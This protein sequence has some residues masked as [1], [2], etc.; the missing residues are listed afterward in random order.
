MMFSTTG[1]FYRSDVWANLRRQLMLERRN[2]CGDV[3]CE[4]CHKPITN[5]YDCIAHHVKY[6][7]DNNVNDYEISLNPENIQLVHHKC[8]NDIHKRFGATYQRH[9]Y[10]V[11]GS[12]CAG[13]SS[14]VEQCA[15]PDDLIIDID[16]IYKAINIS[17]SSRLYANASMVRDTLVDMV[18]TRQGQWVNA[19]LVGNV[20]AGCY[21]W[22]DRDR[23]RL[24]EML[25]AELIHIDTEKETCLMRAVERGGDN[26]K[27]VDDWFRKFQSPPP[28]G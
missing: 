20:F 8:H 19:W 24:S 14:Y 25:D 11:Y 26:R 1:Q 13:K 28:I 7:T 16:A 18:K 15:L 5:A 6:L 12:P 3:L 17:R 10:V 22:S 2:E 23:Q 4:V 21:M 9:I 27:F